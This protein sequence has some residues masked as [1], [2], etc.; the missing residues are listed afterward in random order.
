MYAQTQDY[1]QALTY[2]NQAIA[3]Q[4]HSTS[5]HNSKGN[6]LI[7]QGALKAAEEEY[8]QAIKYDSHYAIGYNGMG[9]CFYLQD[10]LIA[11]RKS[12]AK[13]IE[14]NPHFGDAYYNQGVLLLKL[15]EYDSAMESLQKALTFSPNNPAI[16]GQIAQLGVVVATQ[17]KTTLRQFNILTFK[18]YIGG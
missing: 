7:R 2:L 17:K 11:A 1:Q 15:G 5:F 18:Q 16:D 12:Y 9:R 6:V 10:K 3:L 4:P 8:R 14:L 13:A